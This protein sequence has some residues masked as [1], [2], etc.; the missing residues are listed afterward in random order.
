MHVHM[1]CHVIHY[2]Q[3]PKLL[4]AI[5]SDIGECLIGTHNCSQLCIELDGGYECDCS[6]G[7]EVLDDE[8]TCEGT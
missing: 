5:H 2:V 4:Y 1:Y 6:E 3:R 7:Y 8:I